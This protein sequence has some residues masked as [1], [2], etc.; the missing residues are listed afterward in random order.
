MNKCVI[1]QWY[2]VLLP[3][4]LSSLVFVVKFLHS[5]QQTTKK[6]VKI[7]HFHGNENTTH[8]AFQHPNKWN[9]KKKLNS[10]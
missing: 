9:A 7:A 4:V 2:A 3:P 8:Y 1:E 6:N 10:N 5:N